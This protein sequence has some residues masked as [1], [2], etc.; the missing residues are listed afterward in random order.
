MHT[1]FPVGKWFAI[2]AARSDEVARRRRGSHAV[3]WTE[4]DKMK[5]RAMWR[6]FAL[7][8]LVMTG[9]TGATA[10]DP[11]SP[12]PGPLEAGWRGNTVCVL[13]HENA[14]TRA[15]RCT[16]PPGGGHERHFH[17]AHWGYILAG[18][19]MQITS[20]TGAVVRELKAGDSWW[21]DG[22]AWHEA[23]NIGQTTGVYLIVEPKVPE[24]Q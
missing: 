4:A 13:L 7:A 15:L 12:L 20:A 24:R 3:W 22:L 10:P 1:R 18:S 5:D 9:A 19:T 21:S 2:G 14:R 11:L 17:A 6:R 8:V 16:F 23:L